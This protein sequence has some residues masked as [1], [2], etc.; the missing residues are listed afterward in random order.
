MS[1]TG[2]TFD[3]RNIR[4]AAGLLAGGYFLSLGVLSVAFGPGN[5]L[6]DAIIRGVYALAI[7]AALLSTLWALRKTT[8]YKKLWRLMATGMALWIT[9][10]LTFIGYVASYGLPNVPSPNIADIFLVAYVPILLGVMLSL[11]RI[12]PPFDTEKKHFLA[13]IAMAAVTMLVILCDLVIL[14]AW[15]QA[16]LSVALYSMFDW[17]AFASLLLV[18]RRFQ[19]T[20]FEGWIL[21]LI[22]AFTA[23]IFG[24]IAFYLNNGQVNSIAMF[25]TAATAVLIALS[26]I[27]EVT[28]AFIGIRYR[29]SSKLKGLTRAQLVLQNPWNSVVIP[30]AAGTAVPVVWLIF[31]FDKNPVEAVVL[32]LASVTVAALSIYRN[33]LFIMDNVMLLAT[34][35]RDGLTGLNNHRYFQEAL[36]R[37]VAKAGLA[38]KQLS[39]LMIDIDNFSQ[40]NGRLGHHVGDKLLATVGSSLASMVREA[41]EA[42]R[43][44]G[45]KFAVILP[46][47]SSLEAGVFA[48]RLRKRIT[49]AIKHAYPE[50]LLTVTVGISTYPALAK[51]KEGLIATADG[52]L[53]WGKLTGKN[54]VLIYHP[55]VVEVL[56]AEE[57]ARRAEEASYLDLVK[58]LADAVDARDPYTRLHSQGVSELATKL[59]GK[60]SLDPEKI[61]DVKTAGLLHDVGKIGVPDAVLNKPGRLTEEEMA[62]IKNHPVLSAQIIQSTS[63]GS[64]VP[65]VRAHHE[66]WDGNGY[67]DAL[68]GKKIPFEA[69]ILAIA[70]TFDAMTT[71]RPYRKALSVE[72]ALAEIKRCS[73]TQFDPHLVQAFLEMFADLGMPQPGS[74]VAKKKRRAN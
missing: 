37:Y 68:K 15:Q 62:V 70:D 21:L 42:C 59:A 67:P 26:A 12:Q 50:V 44:S 34:T 71:D 43:L 56:S 25:G 35:L 41:E 29:A 11:G 30:L 10:E 17:L 27:D 53:Y 8:S 64:I 19:D 2:K 32:F 49:G 38:G 20:R 48:E 4:V 47:S 46:R 13:T 7:V 9:G 16:K 5:A 63:L 74:L 72:E 18:L 58:S 33:R 69:R 61:S 45:D 51:D 65:I 31:S 54:T 57:R 14:P 39:L 73:G 55:D 3:K 1:S 22:G 40:I 28:G 52:A 24:D 36:S 60:I 23:A 6:T 66:R